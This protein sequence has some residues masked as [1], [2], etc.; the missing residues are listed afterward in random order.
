MKRIGGGASTEE[1]GGEKTIETESFK[2]N[3]FS[4]LK[5]IY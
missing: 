5:N 4:F 3:F 1:R 2:E